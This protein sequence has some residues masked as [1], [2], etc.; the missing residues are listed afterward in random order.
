MSVAIDHWHAHSWG[1]KTPAHASPNAVPFINSFGYRGSFS[2]EHANILLAP[3]LPIPCSPTPTFTLR[4]NAAHSTEALWLPADF[5]WPFTSRTSRFSVSPRPRIDTWPLRL[6]SGPADLLDG[7]LGRPAVGLSRVLVRAPRSG[8]RCRR[9][10]RRWL[11]RLALLPGTWRARGSGRRRGCSPR[12]RLRL[13]WALG[14]G[15]WPLQPTAA[16]SAGGWTAELLGLL[17]RT[18]VIRLLRRPVCVGTAHQVANESLHSDI[19]LYRPCLLSRVDNDS[20]DSAAGKGCR[21]HP[22]LLH[23]PQLVHPLKPPGRE[24]F[25]DVETGTSQP[26]FTAEQPVPVRARFGRPELHVQ[27]HLHTDDVVHLVDVEP[28]VH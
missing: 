19:C 9:T 10:A 20:D 1:L 28:V 8:Y 4:L 21:D 15:F 11:P 7:V 24:E 18:W 27:R 26:G 17:L 22:L 6:A 25:P 14:R 12:S 2:E 23:L 13:L 5:F 16:L 3:P